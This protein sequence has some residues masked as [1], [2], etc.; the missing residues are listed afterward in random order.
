ML[1]VCPVSKKNGKKVKKTFRTSKALPYKRIDD[2]VES[3]EYIV[4]KT[5]GL[6]ACLQIRLHSSKSLSVAGY[7]EMIMAKSV[8]VFCI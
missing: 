5:T 1:K 8:T 2:S 4:Y 3:R 7:G 6:F